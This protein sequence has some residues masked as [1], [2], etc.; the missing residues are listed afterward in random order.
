M[1][2]YLFDREKD[3][4][5]RTATRILDFPDGASRQV[6][7]YRLVWNW[8]DRSLAYDYGADREELLCHTLKCMET[9]NLDD[10]GEAL[11][12]VL[13]YL[14]W[15]DEVLHSADY[16][17]DDLVKLVAKRRMEKFRKRKALR[18]ANRG[19]KGSAAA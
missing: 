15:H 13:D 1:F 4:L 6:T 18:A 12:Q 9:E 14:V 16:T 8:Y 17:D 7:A 5:F 10:P 11:G 2:N 19:G 3:E